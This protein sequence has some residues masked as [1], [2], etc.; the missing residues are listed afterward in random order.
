MRLLSIN[1]GDKIGFIA[2]GE[3]VH[4]FPAMLRN[5]ALAMFSFVT[6]LS[7]QD[8]VVQG[9]VTDAGPGDPIPFATICYYFT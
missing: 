9:K 1:A 8:I 6:A 5:C 4:P 7:A 3:D 2:R